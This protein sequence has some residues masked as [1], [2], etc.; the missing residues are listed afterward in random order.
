MRTLYKIFTILGI[1]A[2]AFMLYR[3]YIDRPY[4]DLDYNSSYLYLLG[5]IFHTIIFL[6]FSF[7]FY[8]VA[9]NKLTRKQKILLSITFLI[10]VIV[11][12]VIVLY[13]G[14]YNDNIPLLAESLFLIL[15]IISIFYN[16]DN[17]IENKIAEAVPPI[18]DIQ[19]ALWYVAI[20][21]KQVG[22]YEEEKIKL[23]IK[24]GQINQDT[25]VW[26]EGMSDWKKINE[27]NFNI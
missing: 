15:I 12:Y 22:P 2:S 10:I 13:F 25:L 3:L 4:I 26:T 21:G 17:N 1:I 18:K 5:T 14:G 6:G 20:D 16:P 19:K 27:L 24:L 7:L 11:N 23:L 9:N 8:L